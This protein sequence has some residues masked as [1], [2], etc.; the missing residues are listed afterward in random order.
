MKQIYTRYLRVL[1]LLQSANYS[2]AKVSFLN[3]RMS[4]PISLGLS[5]RIGS[6]CIDHLVFLIDVV[7][8]F[9]QPLHL[10]STS[11]CRNFKHLI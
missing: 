9:V 6:L 4:R 11:A 5:K 8:G 10:A 3:H 1:W 2:L 7:Y